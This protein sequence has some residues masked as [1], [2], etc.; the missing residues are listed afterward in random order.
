MRILL[1]FLFLFASV[2]AFAAP[3][4]NYDVTIKD[5][6]FE[7]SSINVSADQRFKITIKNIGEGPAEFENLSLRVEKVLGPGVTSFVVIHPLKPNT[8]HFIDEFHM[9]MQGFNIISK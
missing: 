2:P 5:G 8:Y 4:P 1:A 6:V 3:L 7:P 9:N